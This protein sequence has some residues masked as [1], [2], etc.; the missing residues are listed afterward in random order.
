LIRPQISKFTGPKNLNEVPVP[1]APG[2]VLID[3]NAGWRN[4]RPVFDYTKCVNCLQCYL[5]CPDGTI[6][7]SEDKLVVDYDFCKGCGICAHECK[8]HAINMIPEE[9]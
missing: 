1:T 9:E 5:V 4:V 6:Y 7:K 8:L 2:G 3:K